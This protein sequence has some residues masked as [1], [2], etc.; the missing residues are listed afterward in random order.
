[1]CTSNIPKPSA[2]H[3]KMA[4]NRS[5]YLFRLLVGIALSV[6]FVLAWAFPIM[7][8]GLL[9]KNFLRPFFVPIYA[10]IDKSSHLR[11]FATNY[12]YSKPE[13]ADYFAISLIAMVSALTSLS[14]VFVYQIQYNT[15]PI[16]LLTLYYFSWVGFGGRIMGAAY[17]LA[18]KEVSKYLSLYLTLIT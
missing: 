10:A 13:Y 12:V 2:A 7:A 8:Q 14:I 3:G 6:N 4:S 11:W 1:M 17:T 5:V 15:I 18:H 16:W 9:W